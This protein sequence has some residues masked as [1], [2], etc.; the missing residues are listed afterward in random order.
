VALELPLAVIS[1]TRTPRGWG[2]VSCAPPE[3]KI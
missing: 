3:G 1:R 2:E